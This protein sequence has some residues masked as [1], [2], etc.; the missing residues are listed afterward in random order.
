[1]CPCI[2]AW[3]TSERRYYHLKRHKRQVCLKLHSKVDKMQFSG[4][5]TIEFHIL[6]QTPHGKGTRT[7]KTALKLKQHKWKDKG[8]ALSQEMA[9]RL[10]LI[11][12]II[13]QRPTESEEIVQIRIN[14]NRSTALKRSV[15]NYWGFNERL[16]SLGVHVGT[17][18]SIPCI[19]DW[20]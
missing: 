3:A 13:S 5:D 9:T 14:Y 16:T 12:W 18:S 1:M 15:I 17:V 6:P 20:L 4:T 7:T 2:N 8:T 11:K 19:L 10:S